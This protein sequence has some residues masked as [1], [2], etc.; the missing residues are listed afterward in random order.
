MCA[1][2]MQGGTAFTGVLGKTHHTK[3]QGKKMY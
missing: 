3:E 2:F 1:E